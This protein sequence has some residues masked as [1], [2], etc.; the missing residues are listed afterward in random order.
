MK[1][2]DPGHI[3]SP[4]R[5]AAQEGKPQD[6]SPIQFIA[7]MKRI[8]PGYPGN[9]GNPIDGSNCQEVIRVLIDRVKYLNNQIDCLENALTLAD[10]RA[11]LFRFEVR[12]AR[13]RGETY[14]KLWNNRWF[15]LQNQKSTMIE[16]IPA[17]ETCGHI[18]CTKHGEN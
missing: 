5:Y 15:R 14:H 8:G 6:S 13:R 16:D 7:F 17:C 10:L 12:A 2:L 1:I 11:I 4:D 9:E 18:L 3:Y